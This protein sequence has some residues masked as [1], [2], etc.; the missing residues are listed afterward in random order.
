MSLSDSAKSHVTWDS[1][2]STLTEGERV[3]PE[4]KFQNLDL[5]TSFKKIKSEKEFYLEMFLINSRKSHYETRP[6]ILPSLF[7]YISM[8]AYKSYCINRSSSLS[9][10][11]RSN[12][13]QKSDQ[14]TKQHKWGL[15]AFISQAIWITMNSRFSM[16]QIQGSK[17]H[18]KIHPRKDIIPC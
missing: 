3:F 14:A 7:I 2:K 13:S 9:T 1:T 4:S 11:L 6:R 5:F 16:I 15:S 17:Q 10:W 18:L 12:T 8:W